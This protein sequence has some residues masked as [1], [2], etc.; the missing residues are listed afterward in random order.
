MSLSSHVSDTCYF[1]IP[2]VLWD[3]L[4]SWMQGAEPGELICP[5]IALTSNPAPATLYNDDYFWITKYMCLELV[6]AMAILAIFIPL[7]RKIRRGGPPQG[8]FW[9]LFEWGLLFVRDGIARPAIGGKG[10]DR[11]LPFLWTLFF[12]IL[13]CNLLGMVPWCGSATG[14]ISVTMVLACATFIT[15]VFSGSK[16]FGVIGF[17]RAQVPDVD[18]PLP[19]AIL[20]KPLLF[21]VEVLGLFV[22]HGVLG[23]R[24]VANMFAGHLVL[25]V[26]LGFI[27]AAA[28]SS[29]MVWGS[30]TAV[31]VIG[32]VALS[33]LEL[34][35]AFLQA[36]VFTFL[37]AVFIGMAVHRH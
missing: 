3:R 35:V 9:N 34:F 27:A 36:Y 28:H 15:V 37:S 1:H 24:L 11:F 20:L 14:S 33:M 18:L 21:C 12:F 30:V 29:T 7:A 31:T 10:A 19:I 22:K 26:I 13:F 5:H 6:A 16:R 25:V 32:C 8:R 4:P 17:W 2:A 23:V